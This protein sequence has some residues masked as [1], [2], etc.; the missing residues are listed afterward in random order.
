MQSS[1]KTIINTTHNGATNKHMEPEWCLIYIVE[2]QHQRI[3]IKLWKRDKIVKNCNSSRLPWEEATAQQG[4]AAQFWNHCSNQSPS[5][6]DLLKP[7]G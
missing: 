5:M 3:E 2:C 4:A 1:A 7:I 6:N